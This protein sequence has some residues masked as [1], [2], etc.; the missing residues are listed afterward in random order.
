M[1]IEHRIVKK[2][3]LCRARFVVSRTES[4]RIYCDE[5]QKKVDA[6]NKEMQ[7]ERERNEEQNKDHK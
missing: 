3:G 5:C 6:S 2:C 7:A 4:K 1:V